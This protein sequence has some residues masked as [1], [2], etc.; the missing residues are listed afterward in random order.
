MMHKTN[1]IFILVLILLSGCSS[2]KTTLS[3]ARGTSNS[4][5]DMINSRKDVDTLETKLNKLTQQII[6][7]LTEQRRTKIAVLDFSDL[8]GKTTNFGKYLSEELITRLFM[9]GKFEVIERRLLNKVL[10]EHEL[11]SS[12]IFDI[13]SVQKLGKIL[14]VNAIVAGSITDLGHSVKINARLI[15]TETGKL[16]AVAAVNIPKNKELQSLMKS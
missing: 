8:Q 9:T 1:Y 6:N 13:N 7:N 15:G 2:Q 3:N 11:A 12:G 14:G 16:F 5:E 4:R 10:E